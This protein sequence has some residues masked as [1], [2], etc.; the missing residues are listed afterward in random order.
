MPKGKKKLGDGFPTGWFPNHSD[1]IAKMSTKSVL[2]PLLWGVGVLVTVLAAAAIGID[3]PSRE[4]LIWLIV[5]LVTFFI[6]AYGYFAIRD[7]DRLQSEEFIVARA[8]IALM[9]ESGQEPKTI[10]LSAEQIPNVA[11]EGEEVGKIDGR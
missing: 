1:A 3:G 11:V 8:Q 7:P 10:D 6:L 2:S 9:R 5:A 4:T